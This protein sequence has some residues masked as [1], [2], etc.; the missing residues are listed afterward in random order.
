MNKQQDIRAIHEVWSVYIANL[1]RRINEAVF[2]SETHPAKLQ[3]NRSFFSE[4]P[5]HPKGE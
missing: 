3:E 5:F 4:T 1:L 2:E